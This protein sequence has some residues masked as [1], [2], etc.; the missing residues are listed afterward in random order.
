V[1]LASDPFIVVIA[2]RE[3]MDYR[4]AYPAVES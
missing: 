1:V 4:R 2:M 3:Y